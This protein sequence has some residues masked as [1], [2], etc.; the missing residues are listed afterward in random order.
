MG[1]IVGAAVV[2]HV[3][4]IVMSDEART[5]I[6]GAVG[7]TL[8]D[9]LH[10]MRREKLDQL[11]VDTVVVFDSHWFTTV[12]HI[13]TAHD[14]R[15]GMFTSS[16]LPRGMSG[17][18]YDMPGD[19]ELAKLVAQ[20][21][22]GAAHPLQLKPLHIQLP[23]QLFHLL[24]HLR[25]LGG[26]ALLQRAQPLQQLGVGKALFLQLHPQPVDLGRVGR[27]RRLD[28]LL[29]RGQDIEALADPFQRG[30]DPPFKLA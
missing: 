8:V 10:R 2:S 25:L 30:A 12:E 6:Y 27:R 22:G 15:E 16:E 28:L 3:P 23:G 9:G 18:H 4:P 24:L 13:L 19:P 17:H 7:T 11:D 26:V 1:E 21:D 29:R 20:A 5:V 14:R